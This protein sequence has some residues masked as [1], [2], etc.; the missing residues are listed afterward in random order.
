MLIKTASRVP[1]G[2]AR[3]VRWMPHL[4]L[5]GCIRHLVERAKTVAI[6][7]FSDDSSISE[8]LSM[9]SEPKFPARSV[10]PRI[11]LAVSCSHGASSAPI[12]RSSSSQGSDIERCSLRVLALSIGA[13]AAQLASNLPLWDAKRTVLC[14]NSDGSVGRSSS[15][16]VPR[17]RLHGAKKRGRE[18]PSEDKARPDGT[19]AARLNS[20]SVR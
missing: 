14:R 7:A 19:P 20:G 1:A 17:R 8:S 4:H 11:P 16:V 12:G 10:G 15:G 5:R 3:C 18:L 6:S 9:S 2:A 13:G